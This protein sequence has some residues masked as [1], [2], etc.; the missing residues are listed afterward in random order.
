MATGEKIEAAEQA[1]S[2]A[3][4]EAGRRYDEQMNDARQAYRESEARLQAWFKQRTA[5]ITHG[6]T[7]QV[8]AARQAAAEALT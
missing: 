4:R 8:A 1:F 2:E 5:D 7:D 6:Y 3:M